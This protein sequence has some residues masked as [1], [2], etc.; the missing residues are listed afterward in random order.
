MGDPDDRPRV[1]IEDFI[2]V[3]ELGIESKR[4]RA[5][6][7][8]LPPLYYLHV[9]WAR[10]PLTV[11]RAAILA[12]MLPADTDADWFLKTL[13]IVGDPVGAYA[14]IQRAKRRGG[15][16]VGYGYGR[17]YQYTP[18]EDV[19]RDVRRRVASL[20]GQE[21]MVVL[22]AMAGGG[23]IPFEAMRYG[24]DTYANELNPVAAVILEATLRYPA[25]F[26]PA[27]GKDIHRWAD[28]LHRRV[29]LQL[30][31]FYPQQ[32]GEELSAYIWAHTV[33]CPNCGLTVPLSPNWW[34]EKSGDDDG[35]AV[36]LLPPEHGQGDLCEFE[37]VEIAGRQPF[38][39]NET[40]TV[41]RGT[42]RC[43]RCR[44]TIE[45]DVIRAEAE[46]KR[47]GEQLYA[48]SIRTSNGKGFR[49][50]VSADVEAAARAADKL[51]AQMS[52]LLAAGLMPDEEVP[53]M[54]PKYDPHRYGMTHWRDMFTARQLLSHVTH[55]RGLNSVK[56]E[57]LATE[58]EERGRAIVTYLGIM[59]DKCADYNSRMS[60]W[61][62][63]GIRSTFD[64]HDYAF[65]WSFGEAIP[66]FNWPWAT[67]Q[68]VDA[69]EGLAELAAPAQNLFDDAVTA[70]IHVTQGDAAAYRGREPESVDV[71]CVDPPYYDNVMYAECSDF[72]YVWQKRTLGDI[73]PEWFD[74]ELTDKEREAVANVARFEG[75]AGSKKQLAEQDYE[76]KMRAVF[77]RCHTVL[78]P[79]GVMTV[80]FT[81]KRV[82]AWD[83]LAAAL[84]S[85][86]FEITAAWPVHTESE[87]SLHQAK[88]NA[89]SSTILLVCRKRP[90]GPARERDEGYWWDEVEPEV[91]E[92]VRAKV[93]EFEALGMSGVDLMVSTF[94]PALQV[95]SSRWPVRD[96]S[97]KEIRPDVALDEA[98]R[99]V[100]GYRVRALLS[101]VHGEVP[102]DPPT[103]WTI[104]AWD[105]Y[106]AARFPYDEGR[107]LALAVG[108]DLDD[109]IKGHDLAY[110]KSQ[111]IVLREPAR[112][113]KRGKLDPQTGEFTSIIDAI[114]AAIYVFDED[115]VGACRRFLE[116]RQLTRR[117]E[118]V[119]A[120][121][122]MLKAVPQA[123]KE[124]SSLREIAMAFLS[125]RIEIPEPEQLELAFM[126]GEDEDDEDDEDG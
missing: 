98:R 56:A 122:A 19:V 2:P 83:T 109:T 108:V 96:R 91:R 81:H 10:R 6:S 13:G 24:F 125:G 79:A 44:S 71:I 106:K 32:P 48:V 117:E 67:R 105:L 1:L 65:K 34:L 75:V 21:D 120:V 121:E 104:L 101:R 66:Q 35:I 76:A 39:P 116:D 115:G 59:F 78:K 22:D 37:I 30:E 5:A 82:E 7:S 20:W 113:V 17:A 119:A 31:E 26:G 41:S 118:F 28:G 124:W 60:R 64:R 85:A 53:R 68:V 72:F 126:G 93:E 89:C 29:L 40:G 86:G 123:R 77:A 9:W 43:P 112:R 46:G 92:L 49:A 8:A 27:L 50:P 52:E 55:L 33:K 111:D 15:G 84:I 69:Y 45:Y 102:F 42:G 99:V 87:H 70:R 38:D 114:H 63:R 18:P 47:V 90:D 51:A 110:K 62:D 61:S 54:H 57:I 25:Q 36:R 73:Y 80:M 23:S 58:G 103:R 97:G 94:G 107:K 12:S 74:T 11:S 16:Q 100:T 3:Q 88:K 14:E 95:I 4:E